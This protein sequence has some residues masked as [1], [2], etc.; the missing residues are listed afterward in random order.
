MSGQFEPEGIYLA[1]PLDGG[2]LLL[3]AFGAH[4]EF[5]GRATYNGIR[6]KGHPGID[7]QAQ[8]G[9][10]VLAADAGRVIEISV[11]PG[12]FGR[13]IKLEHAWGESLYA[14]I[15][16]PAVDAGQS[17]P[18]GHRL[19]RLDPPRPQS[20]RPGAAGTDPAA[21]PAADAAA[22]GGMRPRDPYPTHLHFA[23]R[24]TPYNRFDGWGGFTD[25]LPY[26]YAPNLELGL[27]SAEAVV[28]TPAQDLWELL[29]PLL[30]ERPNAR[31]P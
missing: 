17:V 22:A 13:Y 26:L 23:I 7:L 10:W 31:R 3:Q 5:H 28:D 20:T 18:R 2:A 25:P 16:A 30:A 4:P 27:D 24:I 1:L 21:N 6:L 14:G 19:A 12:G 11:E 15:G 29:P 8:P 9:A